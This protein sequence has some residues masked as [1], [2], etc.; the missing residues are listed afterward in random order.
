MLKKINEEKKKLTFDLEPT[1]AENLKITTKNL[2]ITQRSFVE[3]A[4]KKLL[5]EVVQRGIDL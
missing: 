2:G 1:L 3:T 5:E 4:I